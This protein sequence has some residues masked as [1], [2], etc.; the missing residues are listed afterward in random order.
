MG[1]LGLIPSH[2]T[3][4]LIILTSAV[5]HTSGHRLKNVIVGSHGHSIF[6]FVGTSI[7]F[8]MEAAPIHVATSSAGG[9]GRSMSGSPP[10]AWLSERLSHQMRSSEVH[11]RCCVCLHSQLLPTSGV[12]VPPAFLSG[13]PGY[14][15]AHGPAS[16]LTISSYIAVF[17]SLLKG[18]SE[19]GFMHHSPPA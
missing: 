4:V 19:S 17:S 8:F 7:L 12:H 11:P 6:S 5:M 3:H 16:T 14:G 10:T 15:W 1:A 18:C 13:S 2:V 9:L